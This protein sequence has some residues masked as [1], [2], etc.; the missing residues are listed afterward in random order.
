MLNDNLSFTNSEAV[1]AASAQIFYHFFMKDKGKF[2]FSSI[3]TIGFLFSV[4]F[5]YPSYIIV[6][7]L[8][9]W[10]NVLYFHI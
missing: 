8:N 6:G 3:Y 2:T 5:Y 1:F 4:R 7:K 10:E 9:G